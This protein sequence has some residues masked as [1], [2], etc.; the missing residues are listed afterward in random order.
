MSMRAGFGYQSLCLTGV[1]LL[2]SPCHGESLAVEGARGV[3]ATLDAA[4][5]RYEVRSRELGWVFAG[6]LGAAVSESSVYEGRDRLG[7]FHELQFRSRQPQRL[8]A[9]IRT[10][11]NEAIVVFSE[12]SE[13]AVS[14]PETLRFPR[15]TEFPKG[16]RTFSYQNREFAPPSFALEENGT[17][18]LLFDAR[19]HAAVIS[20]AANFML[21]SM[22]GDGKAEISS[23]LNAG[24]AGVPAGFRHQTLIAFGAGVNAAWES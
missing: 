16:L 24:V 22:H 4:S 3:R 19:A 20:P 6:T 18:W 17:P 21:A 15:F 12:T 8:E 7:S 11:A 10:Y 5:G 9:S 13:S 14:D 23:G 2:G 1:L